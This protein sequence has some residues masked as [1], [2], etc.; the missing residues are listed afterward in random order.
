MHPPY[1]ALPTAPLYTPHVTWRWYGHKQS[2]YRLCVP[3]PRTGIDEEFL[4]PCC[5]PQ[6]KEDPKLR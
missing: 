2:P 6:I 3:R 5:K 4:I 1:P